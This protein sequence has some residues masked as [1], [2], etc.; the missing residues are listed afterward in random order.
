MRF[1]FASL[2][3]LAFLVQAGAAFSG[4][5]V[6]PQTAA[7]KALLCPLSAPY[8]TNNPFARIIRGDLPVSII[9]QDAMVI[10]FIP[11]GWEHPGHALVVPKRAARNLFDLDDKQLVS[12]MHMVKRLAV[13]QQQ[14]L[15]STGFSLQQNNARSQ[16][17]CHAHFHVIP[18]TPVVA[19]PH[20]TRAEM[21]A[22]ASRLKAAMP[23]K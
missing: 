22:M 3:T 9:A 12:V 11:L 14:A 1:R 19:T 23:P 20:A 4:Q 6:S 15:G 2:M 5:T 7:S 17:V 21:D 8:D 10:A 13:A 16:D 18:N